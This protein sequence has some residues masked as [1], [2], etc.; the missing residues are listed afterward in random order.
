MNSKFV[1]KN[2]FDPH[3]H[4][5]SPAMYVGVIDKILSFEEVFGIRK[6]PSQISLD[7]REMNFVKRLY[8]F[9]AKP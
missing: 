6:L 5:K 2:K 8:P 9:P 1:R 4:E 3:A 7:Q